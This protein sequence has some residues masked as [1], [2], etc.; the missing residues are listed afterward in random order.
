M[1]TGVVS[2]LAGEALIWGS[3]VV[4]LWAAIF[5]LINHTYFVLLEE[6]DLAARFGASYAAYRARVPRWVPLW[7]PR[8][9]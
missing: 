8:Q 7:K 1:I 4:G 2:V 5:V 6:P 3:W 9:S